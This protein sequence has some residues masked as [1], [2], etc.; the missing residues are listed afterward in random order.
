[1]NNIIWTVGHSTRMIGEFIK[2]LKAYGIELVLDVR[3]VPR[4]RKNPQF[5]KDNLQQVLPE[6]GIEYIHAKDLGG[7][8]HSKKDSLNT[9]WKNESFR[10][11]AD[12]MQTDAFSQA[13]MWLK[14]CAQQKRMVLMC[15]ETLPW[16]CHRSLI[17]DALI[18]AGFEVIEI[19]KE[20]KS[21]QHKLTSFAVEE[22]GKITYPAHLTGD[23]V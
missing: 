7:L 8:R 3:T 18:I 9:A 11:Y 1:M 4:S 22:N 23:D 13:L 14:T 12:Y 6:A 20:G 10:S 5:N 19:F 17:A 21:R 16:R 2:L 15:A